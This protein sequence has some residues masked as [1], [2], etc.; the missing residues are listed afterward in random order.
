MLRGR[1]L[2]WFRSLLTAL[3][4]QALFVNSW[5]RSNVGSHRHEPEAS[6]FLLYVVVPIVA[7]LIWRSWKVF[8]AA[9]S[10]PFVLIVG[11]TLYYLISLKLG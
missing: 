11:E 1:D 6:L 2:T 5:F 4:C 3:G 7:A 9:L 8:L 10:I